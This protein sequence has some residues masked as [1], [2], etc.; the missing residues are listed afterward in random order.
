[1]LGVSRETTIDLDLAPA[2]PGMELAERFLSI[3][4]D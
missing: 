3:R 2:N 4:K 1:L